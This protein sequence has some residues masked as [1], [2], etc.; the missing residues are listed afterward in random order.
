MTAPV[1]GTRARVSQPPHRGR[2]ALAWPEASAPLGAILYAVIGGLVVW[3]L[4]DIV[5]HIHIAIS[6]H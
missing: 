1:P 2:R 3:L 4:V 6:W 5:P